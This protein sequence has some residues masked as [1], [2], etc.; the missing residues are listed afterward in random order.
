[1]CAQWTQVGDGYYVATWDVRLSRIEGKSRQT[2]AFV[3]RVL[4]GP[5][6]IQVLVC[7]FHSIWKLLDVGGA[8]GFVLFL[9]LP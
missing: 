1:M 2:A 8:V 3:E 7:L 4:D 5:W 6:V 9:F